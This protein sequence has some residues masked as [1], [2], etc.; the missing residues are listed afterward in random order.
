MDPTLATTTHNLGDLLH[1]QGRVEE[2]EPLYRK[3]L[4]IREGVLPPGHPAILLSQR[5]LAGLLRD[6]GRL[7]EAEELEARIAA[8]E[9]AS[10]VR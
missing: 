8:P 5:G 9:A 10:L 7:E 4:A 6:T 1:K 3:A 2:A